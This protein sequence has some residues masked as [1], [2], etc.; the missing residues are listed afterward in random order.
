MLTPADELHVHQTS[1]PIAAAGTDRNF[2]DR[3]YVGGW[4]A[5]GSVLVAG[6]FGFYPQL[7][8]AD[9]H[10]TVVRDGVQTSLHVSRVLGDRSVLE[11]GPVR[12]EVL[13]PLR[14]I[15][16]VVDEAEGLAADITFTGRHTPLEEPRFIHRH[17]TRAFMDSTRMSQAARLSGWVS[18]DG[19]RVSVDGGLGFR[20]RSWGIRQVGAADPAP[21][22]PPIPPQFFWVWSPVQFADR[23]T[24]FHVNDDAEGRPWNT[25]AAWAP[26]GSE[27]VEHG[28]G[29]LTLPLHDGTRW[30]AGA[31]IDLRWDL[32]RLGEETLTLEPTGVWLEMRGLGYRHPQWVHGAYQGPG[33]TIARE[34]VVLADTSPDEGSAWHRQVLV[35]ARSSRGDEGMGLLEHLVIG[36]Y[37]PL[38]LT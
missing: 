30:A 4:N 12:I 33:L 1:E 10:L 18:L 16:L 17:G 7:N 25:R 28:H 32:P 5:D 11:I 14:T 9:A 13:E 8:V 34:A 29:R 2:Y 22:V 3:S 19:E 37:A 31:A 6:A 27:R 24:F 20:D 23:T 38:G 36:P 26:D 15:R 35:R 21:V